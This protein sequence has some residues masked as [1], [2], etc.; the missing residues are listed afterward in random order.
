[1]YQQTLSGRSFSFDYD[2]FTLF[3]LR[4]WLLFPDQVLDREYCSNGQK[5]SEGTCIVLLYQ[6][7]YESYHKRNQKR[8]ECNV[9][10]FQHIGGE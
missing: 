8:C 5:T 7:E 3:I 2:D 1:M 10:H 9:G 4:R 6:R